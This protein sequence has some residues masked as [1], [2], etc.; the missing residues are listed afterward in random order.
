[1]DQAQ[2]LKDYHRKQNSKRR[3]GRIEEGKSKAFHEKYIKPLA[4]EAKATLSKGQHPKSWRRAGKWGGGLL[5]KIGKALSK[6]KPVPKPGPENKFKYQGKDPTKESWFD[7]VDRKDA[8]AAWESG[9][10]HPPFKVGKM[11]KNVLKGAAALPVGGYALAKWKKHL[12]KTLQNCKTPIASGSSK[13]PDQGQRNSLVLW[14][15]H[16]IIMNQLLTDVGVC[17][18]TT[19]F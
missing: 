2:R 10:R 18:N 5:K 6:K 4:P 7:F 3:A 1:M 11:A 13:S 17:G 9:D 8:K 14:V 15:E 16:Y 12:K 19:K